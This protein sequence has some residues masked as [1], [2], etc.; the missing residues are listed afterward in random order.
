MTNNIITILLV[1]AIVWVCYV[2]YQEYQY[3][4]LQLMSKN[5]LLEIENQ[6]M[7]TKIRY[8]QNYK[9]DVSKTFKIL[10]N[11][12][13]LIKE[14][15]P[16][17]SVNILTPQ[18]FNSLMSSEPETPN[19]NVANT[20]VNANVA[21]ANVANVANA[22]IFSTLLNRFLSQPVSVSIEAQAVQEPTPQ[23]MTPTPQSP[24]VRVQEPTPTVP[25]QESTP[26]VQEP[27]PTVPVQEPTPV[28]RPVHIQEPMPQNVHVQEPS[29]PSIRLQLVENEPETQ[30]ALTFDQSHIIERLQ[31][32]Y[33]KYL[34]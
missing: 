31:N 10:N 14:N 9:T 11:E 7:K 2:K 26:I 1:G 21:N 18:I 24:S 20:N 19:A 15:L 16:E 29:V 22:D 6:K 27:T 28:S 33:S 8:L 17:N 12:L 3:K 32:E 34:M 5:H 23:Q 4:T 13:S 30:D 25:V